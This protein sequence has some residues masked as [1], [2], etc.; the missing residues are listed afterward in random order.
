MEVKDTSWKFRATRVAPTNN[1]KSSKPTPYAHASDCEM[2]IQIGIFFDGTGNHLDI[3]SKALDSSNVARLYQTYPHI[4]RNG[5][6]AIYIPGLG[7][8]FPLIGEEGKTRFG[9]AFGR[10]GDSRIIF[11]LLKVYNAIHYSL[12]NTELFGVQL[13]RALCTASPT[14]IEDK[15]IKRRGLYGNLV[16]N[17][18]EGIRRKKFLAV[19]A[20][21]I[22]D[23]AKVSQTPTICE[24]IIDVFGFS[25]GATEARVFSHWLNELLTNSKLAEIPLRFRFL[26]LMDTVASVGIWE[27]VKNYQTGNTGGHANWATPDRLR[28]LPCVENCVHLVAMHELRKN[29]PLD[30]VSVNCELP[31]N[32]IEFAYPGSHSDVGGGYFPGE[33]GVSPSDSLKLSQIP[34]NHMYDCAVAAK[35]PL[36]KDLLLDVDKDIFI[37]QRDL[38][39]AFDQFL[40]ISTEAPRSMGDWALPYLAWRWQIRQ[41]YHA[42]GQATKASGE[43]RRYLL[44]ANQHFCWSADQ[45]QTYTAW[46]KRVD[47]QRP[48]RAYDRDGTETNMPVLEPEAPEL[49][50]RVATQ[51]AIDPALAAFFDNFVHDSVAGFRKQIVEQ[52]GHWR[53]RRVFHGTATPYIG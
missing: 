16:D 46:K 6:Y 32:C 45:M 15:M 47:V 10:G 20:K 9:S 48:G 23:R 25:R 49:R 36:S 17:D 27:G 52:T 18:E 34:L 4:P 41:V 24:C 39:E 40:N 31:P 21:S 42:K 44:E 1:L 12:F 22:Q 19:C 11:A 7:T 28:I 13:T 43:E 38:Q 3:N 35:V 2:T 14:S 53:Y 30:T 51:S 50:N 37:V 33:L 26:G 29:F 8:P 5:M